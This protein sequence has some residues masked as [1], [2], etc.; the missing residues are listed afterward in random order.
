MIELF[1]DFMDSCDSNPNGTLYFSQEDIR[2]IATSCI[3]SPE[4]LFNIW[5]DFLASM[6]QHWNAN[7]QIDLNDATEIL[8]SSAQTEEY[9]LLHFE[10]NEDL[11]FWYILPEE[12]DSLPKGVQPLV[13]IY[14]MTIAIFETINYWCWHD[15]PIPI[16]FNKSNLMD[17]L[18]YGRINIDWS[19]Y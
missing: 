19:S 2:T 7:I 5:H 10:K 3:E 18:K 1:D 15:A 17:T 16:T 13:K 9:Y 4:D 6:L 14:M 12:F 11:E 8:L